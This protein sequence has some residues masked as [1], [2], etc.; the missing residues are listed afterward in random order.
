MG[1][2]RGAKMTG[3]ARGS[4]KHSYGQWSPAAEFNS[5][6]H[7]AP[8]EA[9]PKLRQDMAR[10]PRSLAAAMPSGYKALTPS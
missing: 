1:R 9:N 4:G 2:E 3:N 5:I 7:R 8:W 10:L 6:R